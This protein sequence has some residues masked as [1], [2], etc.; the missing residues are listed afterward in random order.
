MYLIILFKAQ[1][2]QKQVKKS[3]NTTLL[4]SVYIIWEQTLILCNFAFQ[5]MLS[6]YDVFITRRMEKIMI[7]VLFCNA[8][9]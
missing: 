7:F 3:I 9:T 5:E 1:T 4:F 8:V 2:S 6:C